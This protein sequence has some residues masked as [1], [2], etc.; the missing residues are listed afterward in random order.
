M[1][2]MYESVRLA[3]GGREG[4]QEKKSGIKKSAESAGV[5]R[6]IELKRRSIGAHQRGS[7]EDRHLEITKY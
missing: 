6:S 1:A 7:A 3:K 4:L 5:S 2:H